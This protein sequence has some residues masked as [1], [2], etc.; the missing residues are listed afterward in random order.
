MKTTRSSDDERIK[1]IAIALVAIIGF[2]ITQVPMSNA[3]NSGNGRNPNQEILDKLALIESKIDD[4]AGEQVTATFCISQGREAGLGADW[5]V[6]AD[7]EWEAGLGWA[8]VFSGE[9]T[10][11]VKIPVFPLPSETALKT[12]ASLGR[13]MDICIDLPL[14]MGP[15]DTALLAELAQTTS[16]RTS[17]GPSTT[18]ARST[19]SCTSRPT[20]TSSTARCWTRWTSRPKPEYAW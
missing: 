8:E 12:G 10:A 14:E 15:T 7:T 6:T 16:C 13:G 4:L 1:L 2:A 11:E 18:S 5:I 17:S 3:Q 19:R 20:R 9:G